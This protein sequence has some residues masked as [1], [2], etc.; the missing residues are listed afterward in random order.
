M[1][2]LKSGNHRLHTLLTLAMLL[3]AA[4]CLAQPSA[5]TAE[6]VSP[7][8]GKWDITGEGRYS[9]YV[10]WLEVREENGRLSGTF[11]NRRGSVVALPEIA[12]NDGELVFSIG[13]RPD[14]PKPVHRARVEEGRLLGRLLTG[15]PDAE[16]IPWIGLRPPQWGEHNASDKRHRYGTPV[17]LF[18][19][20]NLQNWLL[21]DPE[22]PAGWTIVEGAMTNEAKANNLISKHQFEN[23]RLVAEYKIEPKS[24]SGIFL[25]GRYEV[26]V[27]DDF[28]QETSNLGHAALY[29]RVKPTLNA[30][31]PPGSWQTLEAIIVGNRLTVT[32]NGKR[33]HDN[34]L[35]EGITGGAL[36]SREGSPGPVM[37]QGDHGKVTFRRLVVTPIISLK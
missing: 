3:L 35:I 14:Q 29:S 6:S 4:T 8:L 28:G 1:K 16:E 33:V 26:Q 2:A 24:N 25:R 7:F 12:I 31:L 23:F 10:Y 21:Q 17:Q 13:A 32:L 9:N 11:L 27:V 36:D 20:E 30:S 37:I 18:N 34:I 19:G 15:I 5:S 22:R